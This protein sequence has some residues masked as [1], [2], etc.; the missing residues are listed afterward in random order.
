MEDVC[1]QPSQPAATSPERK[2]R[3]VESYVPSPSVI[4]IT[5]P[6]PK[7]P[8]LSLPNEVM[9]SI[10]SFA[11]NTSSPRALARAALVCK[12]WLPAATYTLYTSLA[13]ASGEPKLARTLWNGPH[14]R[15]LVRRLSIRLL[16]MFVPED[17]VSLLGWIRT[18][19]ATPGLLALEI[20]V[21][22]PVAAEAL[23]DILITSWACRAVT[24]LTLHGAVPRLP[25]FPLQTLVLH[26]VTHGMPFVQGLVLH[27]AP[28]VVRLEMRDVLHAPAL[29]A[30]LPDLVSLRHLAIHGPVLGNMMPPLD[31][32]LSAL[33]CLETLRVPLALVS[34]R[35]FDVLPCSLTVLHLTGGAPPAGI[36]ALARYKA[37]G[38]L[39]LRVLRLSSELLP[40]TMDLLTD[41]GVEV[42]QR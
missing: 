14:L 32:A 29:A 39:R 13:I 34:A 10:L 22:F 37:R 5:R 28:E 31:D 6:P 2:R 38:V 15:E 24:S 35:L 23:G 30:L 17:A 21:D 18:L 16:F 1:R 40:E 3:R 11:G 4:P 41:A 7:S 9:T 19:P 26:H 20:H 33:P 27:A 8:A 12:D 36:D 42:V 25:A